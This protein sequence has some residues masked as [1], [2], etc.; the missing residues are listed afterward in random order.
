MIIGG[1]GKKDSIVEEKVSEDDYY[2]IVGEWMNE[3]YEESF[4]LFKDG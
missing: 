4:V 2:L 3:D 1:C